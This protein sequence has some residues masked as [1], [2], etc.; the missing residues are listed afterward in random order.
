MKIKGRNDRIS[1]FKQNK[2]RENNKLV[3]SGLSL[4]SLGMNYYITTNNKNTSYIF[5]GSF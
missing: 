1:I 5:G 4:I 3:N 2:N